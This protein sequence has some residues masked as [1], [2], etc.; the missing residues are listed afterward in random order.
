MPQAPGRSSPRDMFRT[1]IRGN[2]EHVVHPHGKGPSA[3]VV[4][5]EPEGAYVP[6]APPL[7]SSC[8][9]QLLQLLRRHGILIRSVSTVNSRKNHI[10]H[11]EE[12]ALEDEAA[13]P[14]GETRLCDVLG[15]LPEEETGHDVSDI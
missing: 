12:A 10:K 4:T 9:N 5:T 2:A 15:V 6:P 11:E 14:S 1:R 3:S 8:D 13:S 7:R